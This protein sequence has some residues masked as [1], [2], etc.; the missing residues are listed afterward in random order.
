M[1]NN[2]T[3]IEIMMQ[4]MSWIWKFP[5]QKISLARW[6]DHW[7]QIDEAEA[8]FGYRRKQTNL[9]V[10]CE[11]VSTLAEW[12]TERETKHASCIFK[13]ISLICHNTIMH[14]YRTTFVSFD[15]SSQKETVKEHTAH[16]GLKQDMQKFDTLLERIFL[17]L[18]L[19]PG[20]PMAQIWIL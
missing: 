17:E 20:F 2:R 1:E 9:H 3:S 10:S 12:P 7:I 15:R 8:A 13:T 16:K 5:V 11:K 18:F 14:L 4:K 19:E 6:C